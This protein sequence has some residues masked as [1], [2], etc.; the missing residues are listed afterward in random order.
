MIYIFT[1]IR[2]GKDSKDRDKDWILCIYNI[3]TIGDIRKIKQLYIFFAV[4]VKMFSTMLFYTKVTHIKSNYILTVPLSILFFLCSQSTYFHFHIRLDRHQ[5]SSFIVNCSL[6]SNSNAIVL[7][8][9]HHVATQ[10]PGHG[11]KFV[12]LPSF[13]MSSILG[14]VLCVSNYV[15]VNIKCLM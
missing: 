1:L 9:F 13:Y 4:P 10:N 15:I 11:T 14:Q 6:C 8:I 7:H 12:T 5:V 3:N 2:M